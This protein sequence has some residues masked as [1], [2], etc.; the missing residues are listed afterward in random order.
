MLCQTNRRP[1]PNQSKTDIYVFFILLPLLKSS[2]KFIFDGQMGFFYH[3]KHPN[4]SLHLFVIDFTI[5]DRLRT[6]R[7]IF[8]E[9]MWFCHLFSKYDIFQR[10]LKS[11][12]YYYLIF[13]SRISTFFIL[14]AFCHIFIHTYEIKRNFCEKRFFIVLLPL[15][16][17]IDLA[18][19]WPFPTFT[20]SQF[21]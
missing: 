1:S 16:F 2:Q 15:V 8:S 17:N 4:T 6:F 5:L 13:L 19:M 11:L 18:N 7:N 20:N 21:V 3:R 14:Y 12:N 10:S 9:K